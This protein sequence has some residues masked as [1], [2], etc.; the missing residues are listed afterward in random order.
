MSIKIENLS[1]SYRL[2]SGEKVD[3]LKGVSCDIAAGSFVGI[4]GPTGSGKT[5]LIQ[6]LAGLRAPTSGRIY[7]NGRTSTPKAM[8]RAA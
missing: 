8:T 4:M 7:L 2:P 5:T 6:L 3:A 1:Y